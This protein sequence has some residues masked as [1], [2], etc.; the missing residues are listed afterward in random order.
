MK[1]SDTIKTVLLVLLLALSGNML[2][3]QK[4]TREK[5]VADFSDLAMREMIRVGIPASI[6]LAQGC[7]ES[8]NGNSSLAVKGNNHFGIKC[9]KY[10]QGETYYHKDDDYN[11]RGKLIKSC[12]RNYDSV[13]ESYVDH[14]NFLKERANYSKLFTYSN[15]DFASWAWGLKEAGYATDEHYPIKLIKLIQD[16]KLYEY[17]KADNPWNQIINY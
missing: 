17:D 6:T 2:K 9:K 5:Y 4:I 14:S 3:G 11:K 1:S 7:L 15:K 12:F 13:L 16:F 10:W 8:N